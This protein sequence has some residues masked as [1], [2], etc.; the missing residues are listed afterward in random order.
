MNVSKTRTERFIITEGRTTVD[1]WMD[2]SNG[3]MVVRNISVVAEDK[4]GGEER[5]SGL[6]LETAAQ[7]AEALRLAVEKAVEVLNGRV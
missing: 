4:S 2:D 3:E 7:V 6:T 1:V 5:M